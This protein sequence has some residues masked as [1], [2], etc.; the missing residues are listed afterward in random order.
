MAPCP[1]VI[2]ASPYGDVYAGVELQGSLGTKINKGYI[3]KLV[4]TDNDGKADKH[5]V[6]TKVDN[7][8]GI[9]SIGDRLIVLHSTVKNGK[10]GNQQLSVFVDADNDGEADGEAKPLIT[11]LGNSKY[12]KSRGADHSTNNIRLGIDG[13]I[14]I[15]VG[16]FGFINAEGSDGTK[17]SLHGGGIVRVRPDGSEL[18]TFV[19]GTR[20]VYDIAI[21]PYMNV[22]TRD[23]TNDHGEWWTRF[24]H[25]IQSADYGYPNLYTHFPEDMLP[26]LA[27]YGSGSGT[28]CLY[29]EEPGWPAKYNKVTMT[30]DWGRSQI[31]I[32]RL[33]QDGAS[34]RD[35]MESFIDSTQVTDLDVDGSGRMYIAAWD[36]AGYKGNVSKGFVSVVTPKG[37]TYKPFPNLKTLKADA[38]LSLLKQP[39]STTRVYAQ[40]EILR[41]NEAAY[42]PQLEGIANDTSASSESRVAAVYTLAQLAGAD[43]QP[44]LLY[45]SPSPRD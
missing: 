42:L 2:A 16:D 10:R 21:D 9:L 14:Y 45:T 15:S 6:Y 41:R 13:W 31:Y 19:T 36:G 11:N 20:N 5:T 28:G 26:A 17:L 24:N 35:K 39:S 37:W 38:L 3:T 25:Y 7:P 18:E 1:A 32:H 22:F 33:T 4:D 12:L 29:F 44:C 27:E 40:Q 23:N 30:A 34:F 43:A 8:R